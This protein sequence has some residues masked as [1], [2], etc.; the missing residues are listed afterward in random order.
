MPIWAIAS[1]LGMQGAGL[2]LQGMGMLKGQ[3]AQL[4]QAPD[5][6]GKT[7][8]QMGNPYDNP[9]PVGTDPYNNMMQPNNP[10]QPGLASALRRYGGMYA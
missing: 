5:V 9:M 2:G 7:P 1:M 10:M 6:T 4:G 3:P 8:I